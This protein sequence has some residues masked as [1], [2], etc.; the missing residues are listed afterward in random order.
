MTDHVAAVPLAEL[1]QHTGEKWREHPER[2]LPLFVA[3]AGLSAGAE[4]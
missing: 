2:V 1:L 3:E 4:A